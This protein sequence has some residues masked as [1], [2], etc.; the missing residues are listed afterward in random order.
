VACAIRTTL[1]KLTSWEEDC[2]LS[3]LRT[4][5]YIKFELIF[6]F[7]IVRL[8]PGMRLLGAWLPL[9]RVRPFGRKEIGL[10]VHG[11]EGT[12]VYYSFPV[13]SLLM[14]LLIH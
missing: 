2:E 14:R 13:E 4:L 11:T 8:F 7:S 12:M 6:C 10:E 1:R 9:G 3:L 5:E